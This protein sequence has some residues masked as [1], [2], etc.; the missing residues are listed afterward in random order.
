MVPD[1]PFH[2]KPDFPSLLRCVLIYK[3]VFVG[4][5]LQQQSWEASV[6][7]WLSRAHTHVQSLFAQGCGE[8]LCTPCLPSQHPE[9]I[10]ENS[11]YELQSPQPV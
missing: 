11:D 5:A 10:A 2:T 7:Q 3:V 8:G 6:R 9:R 1:L 4:H